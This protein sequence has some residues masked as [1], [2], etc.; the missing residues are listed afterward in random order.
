MRVVAGLSAQQRALSIKETYQQQL[1]TLVL[2]K[3]NGHA[4]LIESTA[5]DLTESLRWVITCEI[6][7][8]TSREAARKQTHQRAQQHDWQLNQ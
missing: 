3:C 5:A 8:E 7:Q 6:N 4:D 1:A 2:I